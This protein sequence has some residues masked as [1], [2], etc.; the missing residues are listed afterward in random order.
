MRK[1]IKVNSFMNSQLAPELS[2]ISRSQSLSHASKYD[3][4]EN[5]SKIDQIFPIIDD[6]LIEIELPKF[7]YLILALYLVI[8]IYSASFWPGLSY[9]INYSSPTGKILKIIFEIAFMSSLSDTESYYLLPFVSLLILSL[10][11]LII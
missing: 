5:K 3:G 1:T 6:L 4:E 2:A 10:I 8:Q 7:L 9:S 11:A